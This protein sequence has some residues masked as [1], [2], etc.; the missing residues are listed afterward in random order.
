MKVFAIVQ[1]GFVL[2]SVSGVFTNGLAKYGKLGISV[3]SFLIVLG[4]LLVNRVFKSKVMIR[5]AG[6]FLLTFHCI[7]NNTLLWY[8]LNEKGQQLGREQFGDKHEAKLDFLL[9]TYRTNLPLAYCLSVTLLNTSWASI[10]PKT[11]VLIPG[12]FA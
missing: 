5:H 12:M 6:L 11:L 7:A 4:P 2:A 1:A 9:S 8:V 10:I 3:T